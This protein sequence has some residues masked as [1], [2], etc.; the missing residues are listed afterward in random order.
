MPGAAARDDKKEIAAR[1][2]AVRMLCR[3][4]CCWCV[5]E[6]C[7]RVRG[8]ERGYESWQLRFC[9]KVGEHVVVASFANVGR[10]LFVML[11]GNGADEM[12]G[13]ER[14]VNEKGTGEGVIAADGEASGREGWPLEGAPLVLDAEV[15]S[16]LTAVAVL[17][18]S[19]GS[20]KAF[21]YSAISSRYTVSSCPSVSTLTNFHHRPAR[22]LSRL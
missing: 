20:T 9:G 17:S 19:P 6:A 1:R 10:R 15:L 18:P 14:E 11:V 13:A 4:V 22:R 2:T 8:G 7:C 12:M 21:L 3:T 16:A 5:E